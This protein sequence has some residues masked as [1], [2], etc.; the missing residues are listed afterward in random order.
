[1]PRIRRTRADTTVPMAGF[2]AAKMFNFGFICASYIN[3]WARREFLR[4]T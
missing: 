2:A 1:V 4:P 3:R